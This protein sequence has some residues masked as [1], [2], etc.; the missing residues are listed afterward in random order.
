MDHDF[1]RQNSADRR[2][3]QTQRAEPLVPE[4]VFT[5]GSPVTNL[6]DHLA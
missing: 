3:P 4:T 1:P 6:V 5:P 2:H